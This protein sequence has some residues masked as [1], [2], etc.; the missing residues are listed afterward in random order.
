MPLHH[1]YS[2]CVCVCVFVHLLYADEAV[3]AFSFCTSVSILYPW[4]CF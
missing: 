3:T 2:L 4:I 1:F